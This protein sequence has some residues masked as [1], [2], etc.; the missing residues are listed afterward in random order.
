VSPSDGA[1][2]AIEVSPDG[3]WL[4]LAGERWTFVRIDDP[5]VTVSYRAPG[6]FAGW[7]AGP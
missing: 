5:S 3:T 6:R 2:S 7:G 4:L 1:I